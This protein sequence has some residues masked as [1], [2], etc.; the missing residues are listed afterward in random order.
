MCV[1]TMSVTCVYSGHDL[2]CPICVCVDRHQ[3]PSFSLH[4]LV[5]LPCSG[6]STACCSVYSETLD[7]YVASLCTGISRVFAVGLCFVFWLVITLGVL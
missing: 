7:G 3:L 2:G 4:L 1:V 5:A 6:C